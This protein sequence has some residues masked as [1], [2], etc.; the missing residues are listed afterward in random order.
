MIRF[1]LATTYLYLN[2]LLYLGSNQYRI[3]IESVKKMFESRT[4]STKYRI[5]SNQFEF[6]IRFGNSMILAE[7]NDSSPTSMAKYCFVNKCS[8][9]FRQNPCAATWCSI[10]HT[11][12]VKLLKGIVNCPVNQI[13]VYIPNIL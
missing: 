1:L 9:K 13:F 8:V 3:S 12:N 11:T 5:E 10:K 7:L 4:E 2:V 6:S